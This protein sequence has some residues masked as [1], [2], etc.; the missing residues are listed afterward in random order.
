MSAAPKLMLSP[1]E[2]LA[3][4]RA[5]EFKSEYIRGEIFAMSC[6]SARHI[7][8]ATN[9]AGELHHLLKGGP[10]QVYGRKRIDFKQAAH[11][12]GLNIDWLSSEEH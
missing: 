10:C 6:A 3:R 2:Y 11:V 1:Q 7:R 4:E 9:I 5:A 12:I 8:I